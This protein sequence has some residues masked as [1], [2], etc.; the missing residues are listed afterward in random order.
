M[1]WKC[2]VAELIGKVGVKLEGKGTQA[3]S[4]DQHFCVGKYSEG[5]G[6]ISI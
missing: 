6:W 5:C 4:E 1:H 3:T 2:T